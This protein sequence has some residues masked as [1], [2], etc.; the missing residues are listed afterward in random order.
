M[1]DPKYPETE[2]HVHV[3]RYYYLSN[4]AKG[5]PG[6]IARCD[7]LF[8]SHKGEIWMY[9]TFMWRPERVRTGMTCKA[10]QTSGA[11]LVRMCAD[12]TA[13]HSALRLRPHALALPLMQVILIGMPAS[14]F[15]RGRHDYGGE[16]RGGAGAGADPCSP[17]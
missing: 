1:H 7:G 17:S 14:F 8:E 13:F 12:V 3:T 4:N 2:L 16:L 15:H 9:N 5:R 10:T 6:E 11:R